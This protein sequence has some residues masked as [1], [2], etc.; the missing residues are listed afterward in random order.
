M[1][2]GF[3]KYITEFRT[4]LF[5]PVGAVALVLSLS[6]FG[7]N[8]AFEFGKDK[9]Q[10]HQK[11]VSDRVSVFIDSTKEFDALVASLANTVMDGEK[12]DTELKSK[13]Y[14]N[15]N[16]QYSELRD[17]TGLVGKNDEK[18]TNYTNAIMEFNSTISSVNS[19]RDLR[20]YWLRLGNVL[21][22][23]NI[24]ADELRRKA[25]LQI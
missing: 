11:Y 10:S 12:P 21:R 16:N 24:L 13:I 4:A 9:Y 3:G 25:D 8:Q 6:S 2:M 18:L 15:L 17:L 22:S 1:S 14:T 23:R 5:S 19:P 7:L 20:N